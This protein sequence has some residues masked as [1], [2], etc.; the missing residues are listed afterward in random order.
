MFSARSRIAL[1]LLSLP[2]AAGF[3]SP[4][5][6]HPAPAPAKKIVVG[7]PAPHFTLKT[8]DKQTVTLADLRGQVIV[9]NLWATWCAPCKAEM[10]MM[11]AYFRAHRHKG[12]RIYGVQTQ[13]S[14]PPFRLRELAGVL[15]YPLTLSFRGG[16]YEDVKAV[17]TSYIIDRKGIVRYA[18]AN[19]LDHDEF[20]A[21]LRPLLAEPAPAAPPTAAPK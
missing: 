2:L 9:I 12:L 19:A 15:A 5:T 7:Q 6:A 4:P 3:A 14:I 1:A 11:D 8:F 16:G 10:P 18:Q 13:D 20:D 17:P 21:L